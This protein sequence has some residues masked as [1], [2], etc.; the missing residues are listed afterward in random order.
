MVG[1]ESTSMYARLRML[2]SQ[3]HCRY[4]FVAAALRNIGSSSI[5]TK[6]APR[7]RPRSHSSRTE[8]RSQSPAPIPARS[9]QHSSPMPT[10]SRHA[11]SPT[12]PRT[13][14]AVRWETAC[15]WRIPAEPAARAHRQ[16][17]RE[18][19]P[20]HRFQQVRQGED[21][22]QQR[23]HHEAERQ[24]AHASAHRTTCAK[25]GCRRRWRAASGRPPP[26]AHTS[27]IRERARSAG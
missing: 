4:G 27:D 9:R 14:L 8:S 18:R 23:H 22:S 1:K 13:T 16:L 5:A 15:P 19:K 12:C 7:R 21:V 11:S 6:Y 20:D 24:R 3:Q 17:R 25:P 26:S 2:N 10:R